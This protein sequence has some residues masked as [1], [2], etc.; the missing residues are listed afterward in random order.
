LIADSDRESGKDSQSCA[1][2]E[3]GSRESATNKMYLEELRGLMKENKLDAYIV[4]TADAHQSEEIRECD[5]RRQFISNFD[6]SA[7]TCA[8]TAD[9]AALFTDGRYYIQ[10]VRQLTPDWQLQKCT[11]ASWLLTLAIN[12]TTTAAAK[13]AK[14]LPAAASTASASS[15]SS[16]P[17]NSSNQGVLHYSDSDYDSGDHY[18]SFRSDENRNENEKSVYDDTSSSDSGDFSAAARTSRHHRKQGQAGACGTYTLSSRRSNKGSSR[19][20]SGE[21]RIGFDAITTSVQEFH[22]WQSILRNHA[23]LVGTKCNLVDQVWAKTESR[24][25]CIECKIVPHNPCYAGESLEYKLKAIRQ[26]LSKNNAGSMIVTRLDELAWLF[27]V[28]GGD[29]PY[30]PTFWGYGEIGM[31]YARL[32]VKKSQLS[33]EAEDMLTKASVQIIDSPDI[34]DDRIRWMKKEVSPV[35]LDPESANV[36][37]F[38]IIGEKA[39]KLLPSPILDLQEVKNPAEIEGTKSAYVQDG[40]AMAIFFSDVEAEL[41]RGEVL[42][43]F[44]MAEKMDKLRASLPSFYEISFPTISAADSNAAMV[45]Y[46]AKKDTS[47]AVNTSSM[48]LIDSGGQYSCGGTTDIT[49]TVHFGSPTDQQKENFTLVLQAHIRVASAPLKPG[50]TLMYIDKIAREFLGKKGMTFDHGTSHGVGSFLNVHE[51]NGT[52]DLRPGMIMSNEPGYYAEGEFGI[53][54]ENTVLVAADEAACKGCMTL[55][56]ISLVPIQLKLIDRSLLTK[57]DVAWVDAYH[58]K[59]RRTIGPLLEKDHP[60]AHEWL[61]KNT[62]HLLSSEK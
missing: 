46:V 12:H 15:S 19:S 51:G 42:T 8:I 5:R 26:L 3:F 36:R 54:I 31:D 41:Q 29:I 59:V 58:D 32:Y 21:L 1:E 45:H 47:A 22:H 6:G 30:S 17:S 18:P 20:S 52:S 61:L 39:A 38:S 60:R 24:P 50:N 34:S 43:E 4:Q 49:R 53:R 55:E 57:D 16:S 7:A 62:A 13:A 10:A 28:R 11:P 25:D 44:K 27:N 35:W 37:M 9:K 14:N 33:P 48:Y 40:K 2:P 23:E 56:T